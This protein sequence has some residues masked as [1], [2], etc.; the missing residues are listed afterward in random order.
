MQAAF[1]WNIVICIAL[2]MYGIIRRQVIFSKVFGL[3]VAHPN[4]SLG[5]KNGKGP[6]IRGETY[7]NRTAKHTYIYILSLLNT[8]SI[9]AATE[10]GPWFHFMQIV[11]QTAWCT[12]LDHD[13][14]LCKFH[15]SSYVVLCRSILL[16]LSKFWKLIYTHYE[17]FKASVWIN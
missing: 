14:I 2:K 13:F 4:H 8:I 6:P 3:S 17:M 9:S 16:R 15:H 5:K 7:R 11:S 10:E 12:C 1:Y